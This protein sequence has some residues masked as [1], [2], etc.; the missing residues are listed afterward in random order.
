MTANPLSQLL[1]QFLVKIIKTWKFSVKLVEQKNTRSNLI[2][3]IIMY[4]C[5]SLTIHPFKFRMKFDRCIHLS[6][7]SSS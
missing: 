1:S 7:N 3:N 4:F 2:S 5:L 6:T